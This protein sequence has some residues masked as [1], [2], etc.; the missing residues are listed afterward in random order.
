MA[1]QNWRREL[2]EPARE[3]AR[4][5][6]RLLTIIEIEEGGQLIG[7]KAGKG[8]PNQMEARELYGQEFGGRGEKNILGQEYIEHVHVYVQYT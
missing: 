3:P 6:D 7:Q 1:H 2:G 4:L 8:T 5:P